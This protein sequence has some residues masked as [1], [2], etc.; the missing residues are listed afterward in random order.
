MKS[1]FEDVIEFHKKFELMS[2]TVPR[3]LTTHKLHE[4]A[5]CMIEEVEEFIAGTGMMSG[6]PQRMDLMADALV[7]LVY[8]A[9]GTAVMLGLPWEE[10][11][12]EVHQAN[13]AKT[14]G[15]T[16]RGHPI[17]VRKPPNWV[18]PNINR[19]LLD[20]HYN[21]N[22]EERLFYDDTSEHHIDGNKHDRTPQRTE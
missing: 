16:H 17:D 8:F 4:R 7:D 22:P 20:A 1:N 6:T 3:H 19:V 18:P 21:D 2:S 12:Q 15:P 9:L 5:E 13:M 14:K 11:W 10:L